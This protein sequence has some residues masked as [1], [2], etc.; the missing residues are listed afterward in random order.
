MS[1]KET[2]E[3]ALAKAGF[4]DIKVR[5]LTEM[6]P[7]AKREDMETYLKNVWGGTVEKHFTG[8]QEKFDKYL[9]VVATEI[10]CVRELT[11][12]KRD[13]HFYETFAVIPNVYLE[14]S[15]KKP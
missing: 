7:M 5:A 8:D 4:V 12:S 11:E 14:I 1:T 15:A 9:S 3:T 10:K 13:H 2:W 6:Q